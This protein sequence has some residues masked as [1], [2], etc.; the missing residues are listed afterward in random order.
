MSYIKSKSET[1]AC[2]RN[3][4][5]TIVILDVHSYI[6]MVISAFEILFRS[7]ILVGK[8]K[9]NKIRN[10]ILF[11]FTKI[12]CPLRYKYLSEHNT[13]VIFE[14]ISKLQKIIV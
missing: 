4:T 9:N 11:P 1:V 12:G 10:T 8:K 3:M 6:Y 5:S 2:V 13:T 14:N 7:K